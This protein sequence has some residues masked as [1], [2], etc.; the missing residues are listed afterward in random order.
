LALALSASD[1]EVAPPPPQVGAHRT[2]ACRDM[3]ADR[4]RLAGI[5]DSPA[6]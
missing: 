4:R 6:K 1:T 3:I 2:H 5:V